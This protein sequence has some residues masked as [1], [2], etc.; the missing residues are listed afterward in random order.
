MS[1][2][3]QNQK[4]STKTEIY[5][6]Y[7]FEITMI[8]VAVVTFQ[9]C[10]FG[11]SLTHFP[12]LEDDFMSWII[13]NPSELMMLDEGNCHKLNGSRLLH[14]NVFGG[15]TYAIVP[16]VI[17]TGAAFSKRKFPTPLWIIFVFIWTT[18]C[19]DIVA[20]AL[21]SDCGSLKSIGAFDYAGGLAVHVT[22]GVGA[23]VITKLM[24]TEEDAKETEGKGDQ[25]IANYM[26]GTCLAIIGWM[27]FNAASHKELNLHMAS[28]L[29]FTMVAGFF[30]Y[31]IPDIIFKIACQSCMRKN[32]YKENDFPLG[33]VA[34]LVAVT[35]SVGCISLG[36]V[37]FVSGS[38]STF[39]SFVRHLQSIYVQPNKKK[40]FFWLIYDPMD[41]FISHGLSGI[42]GAL[43]VP[44]LWFISWHDDDKSCEVPF[45]RTFEGFA[46]FMGVQLMAIVGVVILSIIVSSIPLLL[47]KKCCE[48][49]CIRNNYFSVDD[50]HVSHHQLDEKTPRAEVSDVSYSTEDD[51]I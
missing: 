46:V 33:A 2:Y 18:F 48:N 44:F 25:K 21:W 41:I 47:Y 45:S 6:V 36:Q 42:L 4:N 20:Y 51:I 24:D 30:G 32:P 35:P 15:L 22:A 19:Y 9:W 27:A 16:I 1:L 5:I 12:F 13:G 39:V 10:A 50:F 17:M 14:V 3:F 23:L 31:F 29:L 38:V 8:V 40:G 37:L 34:A 43:I 26:T 49:C 28:S 7:I 11:Y